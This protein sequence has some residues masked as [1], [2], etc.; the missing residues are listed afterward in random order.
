M[1]ALPEDIPFDDAIAYFKKQVTTGLKELDD[2]MGLPHEEI[3]KRMARWLTGIEG[4]N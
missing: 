4:F 3:E 1:T 2:G